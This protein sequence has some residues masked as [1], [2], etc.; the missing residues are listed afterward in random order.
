MRGSELYF[1]FFEQYL[2]ELCEWIKL[3]LDQQLVC[4]FD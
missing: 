1:M 3:K 4:I 2:F